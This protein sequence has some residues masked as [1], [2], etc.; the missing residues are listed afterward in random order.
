[1]VGKNSHVQFA[2]QILLGQSAGMEAL[3]SGM[4]ALGFWRYKLLPMKY[5]KN[6]LL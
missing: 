5:M 1:M 4:E 3:G 6:T 2:H